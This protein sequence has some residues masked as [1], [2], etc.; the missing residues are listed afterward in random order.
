MDYFK[1]ISKH[2]NL[3]IFRTAKHY[4]RFE[5]ISHRCLIAGY[6]TDNG[7]WNYIDHVETRSLDPFDL[8]NLVKDNLEAP[9]SKA[10][11]PTGQSPNEKGFKA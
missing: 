5:R 8:W 3:I 6:F 11:V 2:E 1:N 9:K 10:H 7:N 4:L